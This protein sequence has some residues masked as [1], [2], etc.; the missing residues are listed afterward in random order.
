MDDGLEGSR[1]KA[2]GGGRPSEVIQSAEEALASQRE[3]GS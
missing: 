1:R 3:A 2:A